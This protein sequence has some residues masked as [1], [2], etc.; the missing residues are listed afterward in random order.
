[1]NRPACRSVALNWGPW[2]GGMVQSS[3]KRVF[4]AKGIDLIP[5]RSGAQ[6]LI[7]E[8]GRSPGA[9]VEMVI[10]ACLVPARASLR[11]VLGTETDA[12][13]TAFSRKIDVRDHPILESHQIAGKPVFPFALMVEWMAHSALHE[14]PGLVLAGFDHMHVLQGVKFDNKS[15]FLQMMAGK[16]KKKTD[17]FEVPVLARNGADTGC[18]RATALLADQVPPAP[19]FRLP[20]ALSTATAVKTPDEIYAS[21]LFHGP[22]LHALNQ[23]HHLSRHGMVAD[24]HTAPSPERWVRQP[25]RSRW[26]CDPMAID[27]AFQM[28]SVWCYEQTGAVSLP[29]FAAAYRQYRDR[30]PAHGIRI[31][32]Q[33]TAVTEREMAGDFTF[34]D[35]D[36][37]VVARIEGY[38]AYMDKTLIHA[39]KPGLRQC[40]AS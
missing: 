15:V 17:F 38:K 33:V 5:P 7:Y 40:R 27:A 20:A 6:A 37:T 16:S 2:D 34:L 3:L 1:L 31:V 24:G 32:L 26:I 28:A 39:F 10:G 13:V 18:Y 30:F 8:L 11:P 29:S 21:I 12:M 36:E 19:A 25:F 9:P 22:G 23:V 4:N 35:S 14:N